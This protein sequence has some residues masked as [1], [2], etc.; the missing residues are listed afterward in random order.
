MQLQTVPVGTKEFEEVAQQITKS[1]PNACIMFIDKITGAPYEAEYETLKKSMADPN[2]RMLFH[3][4]N[5]AS[6]YSIASHGFDPLQNKRAAFGR[7]TYFAANANYSKNYMHSK[8][9]ASGFELSYMLLTKVLVGRM[10]TGL[11]NRELNLDLWDT[12]VDSVESPTIFSV[13]R[14]EQATPV[15]LIAFHKNAE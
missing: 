11:G 1:Y 2:E 9:R 14:P 15:Y 12:Q 3:G 6:A 13:P 10:T 5:E 8:E 4:T 7:G